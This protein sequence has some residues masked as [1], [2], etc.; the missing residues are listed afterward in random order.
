MIH[1][2]K[3]RVHSYVHFKSTNMHVPIQVQKYLYYDLLFLFCILP[4]RY[5]ITAKINYDYVMINST[6]C[7]CHLQIYNFKL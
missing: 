4:T 1:N 7:R 6:H 3:R 5:A 2:S